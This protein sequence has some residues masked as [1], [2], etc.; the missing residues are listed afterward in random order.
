MSAVW[1]NVGGCLFATRMSTLMESGDTFFSGLV[2]ADEGEIFVDRDPTHFRFVLNWL[3]R[4]RYLPADDSVLAEL[5][6]EADFYCMC[7]MVEA[8][9]SAR[10][11]HPPVNKTLYEMC[12]QHRPT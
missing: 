4:V 5:L 8:I 3:R 11:V 6:F 7:D 1:L 12:R 10:G 9:R 2:R